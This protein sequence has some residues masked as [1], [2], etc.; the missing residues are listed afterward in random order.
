MVQEV[1]RTEKLLPCLTNAGYNHRY[2]SGY[3][4]NHGC[5]VA[6][7]KEK[8][9]KIEESVIYYDEQDIRVAENETARRGSS[10]KTNNIALLVALGFSQDASHGFIVAT[11][12]LFWHPGQVAT[13]PWMHQICLIRLLVT[14]T[15]EL[16]WILVNV[17]TT[18]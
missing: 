2:A 13:S 10:F 9:S 4:K 6:W 17:L 18:C 1:D 14:H 16:G 11:T 3:G 8:Y 5:L 12:H 15:R 7:T